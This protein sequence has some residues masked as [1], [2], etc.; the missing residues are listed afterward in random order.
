MTEPETIALDGIDSRYV[1]ELFARIEDRR[2]DAIEELT[3]CHPDHLDRNTVAV[4]HEAREALCDMEP[5]VAV[6]LL[7]VACQMIRGTWRMP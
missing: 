7:E 5:K 3:D 6:Q 4:I 1:E 2:D